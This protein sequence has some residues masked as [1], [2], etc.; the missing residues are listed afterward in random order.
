MISFCVYTPTSDIVSNK[1]KHHIQEK[2]NFK[3]GS[4]IIRA[5]ALKLYTHSNSNKTYQL[6]LLGVTA[7]VV[8][9]LWYMLCYD[10]HDTI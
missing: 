5:P 3:M 9:R 1:L 4:L 8:Y 7:S 10:T 6:P 2:L